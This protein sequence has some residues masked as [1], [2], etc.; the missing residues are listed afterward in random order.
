MALFLGTDVINKKLLQDNLASCFYNH[1]ELD[2]R[3]GFFRE[4]E[5]FVW[6]LYKY[7][8]KTQEI[9]LQISAVLGERGV[10]WSTSP[11]M[12][13]CTWIQQ[14]YVIKFA[15]DLRQVG[16]FLWVLWFPPPIQN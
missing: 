12:A 9:C 1:N 2:L 10:C 11:F 16:G 8:I 7:T 6:A 4:E 15:S 3:N 5:V 14:P 13:R